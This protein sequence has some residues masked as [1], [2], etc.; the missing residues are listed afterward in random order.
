MSM[1]RIA[2]IT[3][4]GLWSVPAFAQPEPPATPAPGVDPTPAAPAPGV[5]PTPPGPAAPAPAP[6]AD[7]PGAED[8]PPAASAGAS[9]D[10]VAD[11]E[12][13]GSPVESEGKAYHFVGLRYRAIVVPKF[14]MNLFG[15]GGRDV[16]VHSFGPEY[17]L[18][19]DRFEYDFSLTYADYSMDR[20]PF[21]ASSDGEAAW[22]VVESKIKVIYAMADFMWSTEFAPEF[23]LNYGVGFGVGLVFGD[24]HRVQAY[25]NTPGN[26][27]SSDPSDYIECPGPNHPTGGINYCGDDNEHYGDYTEPSW[28]DGGSKPIIFPWLAPQ[29][30]FRYKPHRNFVSRLDI[31]FGT[32]GFFAGIGADYGL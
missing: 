9:D 15:D 31:G 22:E 24:L 6:A 19:K 8:M 27:P 10:A 13:G 26:A 3:V 25:P 18:R 30:G 16:V 5:D 21:K 12:Q 11:A 23:S 28:A 20:T 2:I 7:E 32:S 14:M 29:F 4:L 1:S 17:V